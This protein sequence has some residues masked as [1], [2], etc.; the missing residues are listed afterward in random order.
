MSA[1]Q[2]EKGESRYKFSL[3][4][5]I[6]W[7]LAENSFD[8]RERNIIIHCEVRCPIFRFQIPGIFPSDKA[9]SSAMPNSVEIPNTRPIKSERRTMPCIPGINSADSKELDHKLHH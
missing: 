5:S 3:S 6:W 4:Q 9:V 7:H 8:R 1:T 2:F